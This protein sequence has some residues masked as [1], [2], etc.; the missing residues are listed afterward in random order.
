MCAAVA[1]GLLLG[2]DITVLRLFGAGAAAMVARG[3][4]ARVGKVKG[5]ASKG[6][7]SGERG[8]KWI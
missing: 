6:K 1:V 7:R 5:D 3:R 4:W 8:K 2:E